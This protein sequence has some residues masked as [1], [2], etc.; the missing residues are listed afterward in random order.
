[1]FYQTKEEKFEQEKRVRE[2]L[3]S[4]NVPYGEIAM[5]FPHHP[6]DSID[7]LEAMLCDSDHNDNVNHCMEIAKKQ[8]YFYV[9]K[10]DDEV[11]PKI[12]YSYEED[13]KGTFSR[14]LAE[15]FVK[16]RFEPT[17]SGYFRKASTRG[18]KSVKKHPECFYDLMCLGDNLSINYEHVMNPYTK[19][20]YCLFYYNMFSTRR[21]YIC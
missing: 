5:L 1:M 11:L 20:W 7:C 4:L 21:Y 3:I 18:S 9:G 14:I 8:A 19:N 12:L 2:K 17:I 13:G 6:K 16:S 15:S 10:I